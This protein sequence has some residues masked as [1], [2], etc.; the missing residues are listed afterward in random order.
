MWF[1]AYVAKNCVQSA[2]LPALIASVNQALREAAEG[3][4]KQEATKPEPVVPVNKSVRP[5]HIVCFFDGNKFKSLRRHLRVHH[6]MSPEQYRETFGLRRDYPMVAPIM[7]ELDPRWPRQS[8]WARS[9]GNRLR[10]A[11]PSQPPQ[12]SQ[13]GPKSAEPPMLAI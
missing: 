13:S 11:L 12:A 1:A 5:D 4:R 2:E 3:V 6:N 7:L 9:V 8:V 10:R